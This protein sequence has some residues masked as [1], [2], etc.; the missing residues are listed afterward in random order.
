MSQ[1]GVPSVGAGLLLDT[2]K[3]PICIDIFTTRAPKTSQS[4]LSLAHAGFM[5]NIRLRTVRSNMYAEFVIRAPGNTSVVVEGSTQPFNVV[6][7]TVLAKLEQQESCVL[8]TFWIVLSDTKMKGLEREWT[9]VGYVA[10][11][12]DTLKG[13]NDVLT[14]TEG[15][16]FRPL[17]IRTAHILGLPATMS[18]LEIK[19]ERNTVGDEDVVDNES[20]TDEID[21]SDEAREE[22]IK[23]RIQEKQKYVLT[24]LGDIPRGCEDVAP[25][26]NVLFVCK[27]NPFTADAD[28][29][30]FFEQFGKV[31]SC[32]ILREPRTKKSLQYGFVEF[33]TVEGCQRALIGADNVIVDDRRIHVDFCQSVKHVWKKHRD[34][35]EE[36]AKKR[37]IV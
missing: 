4:M 15:V 1:R 11:G 16:P 5:N 13:I 26:E 18:L 9:V 24:L 12:L 20:S 32:E 29:A 14:S 22:R 34:A 10:E 6:I 25:P 33:E 30:R 23:R 8:H 37:K 2:S 17:R 7:G 3:G 36:G 35:S 31:V 19:K 28:L 21:I 27:L